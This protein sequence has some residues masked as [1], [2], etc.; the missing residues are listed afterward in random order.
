MKFNQAKICVFICTALLAS[1]TICVAY[2]KQFDSMYAAASRGDTAALMNAVHRG[3][4]INS[5]DRSGN[6][7]ICAAIRRYDHQAYNSFIAAGA[8]DAP[9]CLS[10]ISAS[11]YRKFMKSD[12]VAVFKHNQ[13]TAPISGQAGNSG[14]APRY[15]SDR[16]M[17]IVQRELD[18]TARSGNAYNLMYLPVSV[19]FSLFP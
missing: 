17:G 13:Y 6:T 16:Q 11:K 1:T 14:Y 2:S 19:M 15:I 4:N 8:H 9:S 5:T 7:G 18:S 12:K 3:L 10:R